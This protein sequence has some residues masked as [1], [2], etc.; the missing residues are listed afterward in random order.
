[1]NR[2]TLTADFL[3]DYVVALLE[4]AVENGGVREKL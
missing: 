3:E 4:S 1:M 2:S